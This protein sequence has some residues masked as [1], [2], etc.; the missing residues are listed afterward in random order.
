[1]DDSSRH[2][3]MKAERGV[4]DVQLPFEFI[5]PTQNSAIWPYV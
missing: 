5:M 4:L 2:S 3:A 1:M